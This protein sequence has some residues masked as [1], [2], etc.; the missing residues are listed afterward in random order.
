MRLRLFEKDKLYRLESGRRKQHLRSPGD[1]N[2]RCKN[3]I[4]MD[5]RQVVFQMAE[6]AVP[7]ALFR[8]I[9]EALR[10]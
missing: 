4:G 5:D 6:V 1:E 2:G 10:D 7:R 3:Q 9:L 8:A